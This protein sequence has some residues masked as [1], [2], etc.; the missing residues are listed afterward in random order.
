MRMV[1]VSCILWIACGSSPK[2]S[3]QSNPAYL[4]A[5]SQ[6]SIG[7]VE[8]CEKHPSEVPATIRDA[9]MDR[10]GLH[11]T[12]ANSSSCGARYKLRKCNAVPEA[13]RYELVQ[14]TACNEHKYRFA[15]CGDEGGQ[16]RLRLV[17]NTTCGEMTN[18]GGVEA[19]LRVPKAEL[20]GFTRLVELH[21]QVLTLSP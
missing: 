11:M 19:L 4:G 7:V 8:K 18:D 12:V 10:F 21:D 20:E 16:G 5:E 3:G 14:S 6:H 17:Q 9:H 13:T 2:P 15:R 1:V